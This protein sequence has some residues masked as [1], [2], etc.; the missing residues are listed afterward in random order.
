MFG[1]Q[2]TSEFSLFE[3]FF[4]SIIIQFGFPAGEPIQGNSGN[5]LAYK[6]T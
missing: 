6:Q 4:I 3:R 2:K 5:R 1:E